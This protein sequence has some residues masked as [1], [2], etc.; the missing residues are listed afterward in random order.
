MYFVIGWPQTLVP[1][2]NVHSIIPNRDNTIFIFLSNDSLS[3]WYCRPAVQILLYKRALKC[4]KNHGEN[5]AAVWK[6]DSSQ[7]IIQTSSDHLLFFQVVINN[8]ND[9]ILRLIQNRFE[10]DFYIIHLFTF[11]VLHSN[12]SNVEEP[13]RIPAY[14]LEFEQS[15]F[16]QNGITRFTSIIIRILFVLINMFLNSLMSAEEEL[17]LTTKNGQLIGV[18]WDGQLDENLSYHIS[19]PANYFSLTTSNR[20]DQISIC[21]FKYSTSIGGFSLVFSNGLGGFLPFCY[22]TAETNNHLQVE[23]ISQVDNAVCTAINHR[24][25]L[26]AFGLSS[27]TCVLCTFDEIDHRFIIS[28]QLSL[29]SNT[30]PGMEKHLG[31]ITALQWTPDS[32][33]LATA[34]NNGGFALWTVFGSLLSCSLTW[35]YSSMTEI[36]TKHILPFRVTS[37]AFGQEGFHLWAATI[38]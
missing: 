14:T 13:N 20:D 5:V 12:E 3:L 31:A 16:I 11:V 4:L 21:D 19:I 23:L 24:F 10:F 37:F 7:I 28:H 6:S 9:N 32:N 2:E 22:P 30:F 26:I 38:P 17:V 25:A 27:S 15:V 34:W 18:H 8:E 1:N 29:P 33:V 35:D 36:E